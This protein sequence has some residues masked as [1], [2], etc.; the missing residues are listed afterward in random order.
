LHAAL[1]AAAVA[2][3]LLLA[4]CANDPLAQQYLDGSNKGFISG[5]GIVTEVAA[6]DRGKPVEFAGTDENGD[7]VSSAD[8]EGQVVVLNFWYAGCAPCRAE[9]PDLEK[10]NSEYAGQDVS[11][12]GVNVRDQASTAVSFATTFG[13]TYPS[14]IDTDGAMQLAFSGTVAP[15]AVPTTLVIDKEGRVA[16]RILGQLTEASILDSL[17]KSNLESAPE[18]TPEAG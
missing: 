1:A 3:T 15:N 8:Y 17:I 9:A 11:F 12:L 14:I 13:V 16:A 6:A 18:P 4:G 10:L 7:A 5:D 2:A